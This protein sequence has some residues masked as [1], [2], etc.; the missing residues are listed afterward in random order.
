MPMP[1]GSRGMPPFGMTLPRRPDDLTSRPMG[2]PNSMPGQANPNMPM[3]GQAPPFAN[4]TQH[5]TQGVPPPFANPAQQF[6]NHMPP[7]FAGLSAPVSA[8]QSPPMAPSGNPQQA[9]ANR[10]GGE[11]KRRLGKGKREEE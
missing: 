7:P 3:P 10:V 2:P 9:L 8:P 5:F 11:L 4:P 6:P 1:P